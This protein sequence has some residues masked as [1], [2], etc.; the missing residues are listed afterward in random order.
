MSGGSLQLRLYR[1][2]RRAGDS[3]HKAAEAS[4]IGLGEA[5][6]IDAEDARYPPPSEAYHL[7]RGMALRVIGGLEDTP[8]GAAAIN[9]LTGEKTC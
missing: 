3:M 9:T 2:F 1:R 5:K 4:G 8:L 7:T 6:L